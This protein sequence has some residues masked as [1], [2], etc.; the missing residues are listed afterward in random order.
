MEMVL[1]DEGRL[2]SGISAGENERQLRL[3]VAD[4]ADPVLIAKSAIES[5]EM[6]AVSMMPVGLLNT[7]SDR[8]VIDLIAY[9]RT[10]KQVP[11][12]D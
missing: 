1:T 10:R 5:R 6:A 9:L 12:P 2:Y 7:L 11:L 3:K 8:E 4:Q